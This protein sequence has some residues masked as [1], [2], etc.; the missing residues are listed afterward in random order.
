MEANGYGIVQVDSDTSV[1]ELADYNTLKTQLR[2]NP[3]P[4]GDGG[5]NP[6]HAASDCPAFGT[7]WNVTDNTLPAIPQRAERFMRDGA[8]DGVGLTGA[9][10]QSGEGTSTGTASAGSGSV[11]ST[12]TGTASRTSGASSS[13]SGSGSSSA[14]PQNAGGAVRPFDGTALALGTVVLGATVFGA[15]LL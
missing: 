5:Y 8:G 6:T 15:L 2:A 4:Q 14:T 9:G 13:A 10:S 11:T 3:P 12:A 1:T 7:N